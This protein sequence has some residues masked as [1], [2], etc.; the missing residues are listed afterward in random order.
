MSDVRTRALEAAVARGEPGAAE[1]LARARERVTPCARCNG[2]R[3]VV[4]P[5]KVEEVRRGKWD[6]SVATL[7]LSSGLWTVPCP[8][9]RSRWVDMG[10]VDPPANPG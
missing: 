3:R 5:E 2:S 1:A 10:P 4:D 7:A 8:A 9:C 6:M